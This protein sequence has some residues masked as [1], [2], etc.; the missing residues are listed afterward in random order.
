MS[1]DPSQKN[2][3]TP[4]APCPVCGKPSTP[5][6]RP[7]C[8]GRCA[9]VDLQRWLSERYAIPIA[10]NDDKH[11]DEDGEG[12]PSDGDSPGQGGRRSL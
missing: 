2:R 4:S 10:K 11:D 7:F 5:A 6:S 12:D 9:D 8:S 3:R 1:A